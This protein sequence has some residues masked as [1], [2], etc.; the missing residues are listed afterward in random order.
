MLKYSKYA[1]LV[2]MLVIISVSGCSDRGTNI[3]SRPEIDYV[4]TPQDIKVSPAVHDFFPEM[5]FQIRNQFHL[6]EVA[7]YL[8]DV[9]FPPPYGPAE[10][11][12]LLILL[13]PQD[14]DQFYYFNHGLQQLADE[15][16]ADGTIEPMAICCL[17]SDKVFGGY[18]FAGHYPPA[19]DYDGVVGDALIEY[20]NNRFP[21]L[22]TAAKRGIGGTG[23][24]AYG[25]FR[26]AIIH[27]DMFSSITVTDGPLDFDG[28]DGNSGLMELFDDALAEQALDASN[29]KSFDT[30]GAWHVS[31]MFIGGAYAFSPHDTAIYW[32]SATVFNPNDGSLSLEIFIDSIK[33][34]TDTNTLIRD[35]V[36]QDPDLDFHLPFDGHGNA[37]MPIWSMWLDN[38]LESLL[39]DYGSSSLAGMDILVQTS[40]D[41]R[42]TFYDQTKSWISTMSNPPYS[43]NVKVNEYSGYESNPATH[44]QYLYEIMRNML[45]F[46]SDNFGN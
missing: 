38:N 35:V 39:A 10:E 11:V 37:Y 2:L 34:I 1:A 29:F 32:D 41:A 7:V 23:Q 46:H 13:P 40:P 14:G 3:P 33:Q 25:A 15:M 20:L 45:K 36:T 42:Y 44:D 28:R 9:A 18:F 22:N 43:Y 26:S 8:P 4:S 30:S 16:I 6:L 19:G 17:G 21:L 5:L 27:S 31:R 12:P 24:G